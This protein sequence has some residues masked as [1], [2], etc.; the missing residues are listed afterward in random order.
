MGGGR[1]TVASEDFILPGDKALPEVLRL[2]TLAH[3]EGG[4]D[5][6]QCRAALI[7]LSSEEL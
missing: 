1:R 2:L 4:D 3:L 7:R 5:L 6:A